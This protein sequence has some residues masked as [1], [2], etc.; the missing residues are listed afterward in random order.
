MNKEHGA[1]LFFF[2]EKEEKVD[3]RKKWIGGRM[4]RLRE[5]KILLS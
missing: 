5:T 2:R 3:S 4:T 1:K